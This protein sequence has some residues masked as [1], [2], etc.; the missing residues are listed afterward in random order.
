MSGL[1]MEWDC[2]EC[3]GFGEVLVADEFL[4]SQVLIVCSHCSTR[5]IYA[6]CG[7][8]GEGGAPVDADLVH[9]AGSWRC[10]RCKTEYRLPANFYERPTSF[11]PVEFRRTPIRHFHNTFDD[12]D[13]YHVPGA[14]LRAMIGKWNRARG[15]LL[16]ISLVVSGVMALVL[17]G[18]LITVPDSLPRWFRVLMLNTM[19][20]AVFTFFGLV[21]LNMFLWFVAQTFHYIDRFRGRT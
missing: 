17:A 13:P 14:L 3:G 6:W 4:E 19:S 15:R 2:D 8:C 16:K 21:L 20:L 7:K 18:M 5:S 11:R 12:I 9:E 10:R 1:A